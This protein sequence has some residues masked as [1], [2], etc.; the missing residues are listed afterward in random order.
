[1]PRDCLTVL[2]A[3][4]VAGKPA[5]PI[6]PYN[7]FPDW[8]EWVRASIV[9]A[10]KAVDVPAGEGHP[11]DPCTTRAKIEGSDPV[12]N[13]IG[14]LLQVWFDV[15]GSRPVQL[16]DVIKEAENNEKLKDALIDF[17]SD[18]TGHFNAKAISWKLRKF[19]GRIESGLVANQFTDAHTKICLWKV[20]KV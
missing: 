6:K 18:K 10:N 9:W 8:S 1:M 2:R 12:R 17:A 3:Y 13:E 15:L 14:G 5:Q 19:Q 11:H 16:R 7:R 4:I 20:K